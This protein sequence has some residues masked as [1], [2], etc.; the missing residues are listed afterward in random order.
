MI[1]SGSNGAE[2]GRHM[3]KLILVR[4]AITEA[5]EQKTY[6][7]FNES[8]ISAQ[9]MKEI[10]K[11]TRALES[12]T[13]DGVYVSPTE[14]TL[15][16][17][18][19]IILKKNL[20]VEYSEALR[21]IHF[22]DFEGMHFEQLKERYPE[23]VQKMIA[24][25]DAYTYPNGESL[26]DAYNRTAQKIDEIKQKNE[27]QTILICAHAG[28]IRNILSHLIAKNHLLH[29]HFKVDNATLSIVTV[30]NDFAVVEAL[31]LPI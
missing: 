18:E 27:G 1:Q 23:E 7:G 8:Q 14:R 31:N 6:T 3:L 28:T 16:T 30:E 22:G 2:R 19:P 4:H 11:L 13:I 5:N 26:I 9:G 17:V 20:T 24:L 10:E 25:G 29:W 21:E 12:Y 15:R